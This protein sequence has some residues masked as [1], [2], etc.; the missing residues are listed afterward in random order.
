MAAYGAGNGGTAFAKAAC[1]TGAAE[2]TIILIPWGLGAFG[3][4]RT[5]LLLGT[6]LLSVSCNFHV[7]LSVRVAC[8]AMQAGHA[9]ATMAM[10]VAISE[11]VCS[12]IVYLIGWWHLHSSVAMRD[13][14]SRP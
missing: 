9:C 6:E 2:L 1:Q 13:G 7:C 11:L 10:L 12:Q 5:A 4:C 3:A 14:S 8:R